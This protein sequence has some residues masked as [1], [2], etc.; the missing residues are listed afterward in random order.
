MVAC[1]TNCCFHTA[2]PT[3]EIGCLRDKLWKWFK[4]FA[5]KQD[6][7]HRFFCS[8]TFFFSNL[9]NLLG[10][11]APP[12]LVKNEKFWGFSIVESQ[13]MQMVKNKL[14]PCTG[15]ITQKQLSQ[16]YP[17][18]GQ[19]QAANFFKSIILQLKDFKFLLHYFVFFM[20]LLSDQQNIRQAGLSYNVQLTFLSS[21]DCVLIQKKNDK[22][23]NQRQ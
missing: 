18:N 17:Q 23:K 16:L 20:L 22:I 3:L 19:K 2:F 14:L 4:C 6:Q 10:L 11:A 7:I 21:L 8:A 15:S 9:S 13:K 12:W 1:E 5:S